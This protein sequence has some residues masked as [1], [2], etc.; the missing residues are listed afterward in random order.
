MAEKDHD[1][2]GVWLSTYSFVSGTDG[3]LMVTDHYVDIYRIG[4]QV[5]VQSIPASNGSYMMA[6]FSLDGRVLTGSYYSQTAASSEKKGPLY[7]DQGAAQLVISEDGK[8]LEGMGVGYT[9]TMEVKPSDW[10]LVYIGKDRPSQETLDT[11][12]FREPVAT[13]K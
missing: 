8:T 2:S 1:I 9:R 3:S 11:V 4:S 12:R 13:D 7:Y 5:I 6:R 10:K